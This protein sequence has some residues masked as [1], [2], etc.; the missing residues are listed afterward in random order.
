[1]SRKPCADAESIGVVNGIRFYRIQSDKF[2]TARTDIFFTDPLTA[3]TACANALVPALLKRGCEGYPTSRLLERRLEDLYGASFDCQVMKK[4]ETQVIHFSV[5]HVADRFASGGEHLF[6]EATALL[7][8]IL[9]QPV[10]EEGCFRQDVFALER[11]NLLDAIRSRVNDKIR[12]ASLRCVEEMCRG[13]AFAIHAEGSEADAAALETRRVT[14]SWERL[15]R[16]CPAYVYFSGEMADSDVRDRM[17]GFALM[18]RMPSAAQPR[19][20]AAS[21][22]QRPVRHV[23]EVM[24][25]N[26][27]KLCMGLR[28]H[29]MPDSGDWPALMVYNGILGGDLH[30]KLFQNVREKASLAYYA[31]SRLER[32]KGLMFINSGI[33]AAN[34]EQAEAI[35]LEQ[36]SDMKRGAVTTEEFDATLRSLDTAF[37]A[38]QD[39]QPGIAEFHFGQHMLGVEESLDTL[40]E[41]VSRV[42]I[43]DVVRV[44]GQVSLDTVYFLQPA[45]NADAAG[46]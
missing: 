25:V 4:G 42:T 45:D 8:E 37:K 26:Q 1:M 6:A 38:T 20:S 36:L 14:G 46:K 2:K 34:R 24:E 27:G 11:E 5:A 18:P 30:S 41:K 15:V 10:L 13:E 3:E 17:D 21:H 29:V 44:A 33:E 12:Y 22:E 19:P 23:N 7:T 31:S 16:T 39:S 43:E 35:I 40:S 28:T 9:T 32:H